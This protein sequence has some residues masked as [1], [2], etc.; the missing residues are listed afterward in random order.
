VVLCLRAS[1]ASD[2]KGSALQCRWIVS[3]RFPD[4]RNIWLEERGKPSDGRDD[5]EPDRR[6]PSHA[7]FRRLP[8]I[9]LFPVS[10]PI[11]QL[12][13]VHAKTLHPHQTLQV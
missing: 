3:C 12:A 4:P 13:L 7:V 9:T 8:S 5:E 2:Q 1:D 11:S 10:D 6:P